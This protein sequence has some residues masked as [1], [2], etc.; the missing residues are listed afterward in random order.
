M[1]FA[2]PPKKRGQTPLSIRPRRTVIKAQ[3][4][5][6]SRVVTVGPGVPVLHAAR[7]MLQNRISGLPVV[8]A[9]GNH[10]GIVTEGDLLRCVETGTERRRPHWLEFLLSPGKQ[11][12]EY[13]HTHG[14]KVE[15]V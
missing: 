8:D 7:L 1:F 15:D 2:G 9:G 10:V 14:R 4:V 3:D 5:M 11:A 6:T 12:D 13:V